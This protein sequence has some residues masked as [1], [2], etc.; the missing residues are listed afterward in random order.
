MDSELDMADM[1]ATWIDAA[2]RAAASPETAINTNAGGIVAADVHAII[3]QRHV[4]P[5]LSGFSL[6]MRSP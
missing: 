1:M 4:E 2:V 6:D 3:R 5:S